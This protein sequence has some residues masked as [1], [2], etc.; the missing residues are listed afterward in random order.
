MSFFYEKGYLYCDEL[1]VKT[2]CEQVGRTPFYL[3]SAQ[4]LHKNLAAYSDAIA[5]I[6]AA[7]SYAVKANA[8]LHILS[9]VRQHGCWA[10]LV[11]G[12]ELQLALVSGFDPKHMIFNGNGKTI[13][14][15]KSAAELGILINI[16]SEFD[17]DH[18]QQA[19]AL[20]GKSVDVLLRIN[21]DIDPEVHPYISTGV[22]N[23][24][25]GISTKDIPALLTRLKIASELNLVGLH[26][27]L[28]STI[29]NLAVFRQIMNLM[30]DQFKTIR[31]QGFRIKYLNIGGGL[32]I[33]YLKEKDGFPTP[34][35][36]I[37]VLTDL[38][39]EHAALI[40]EPGRS[41][42][43]SAGVLI[44]N[45]I[46]IKR[47]GSRNFIVT[48]GSM[49]ELIR[50]SLYGA[51]HHINFIEPV[52]G[53]I[54]KYDIVGPVCESADFLG[55]DRSLPTPDENTGMIIYDAGAYGYTM[56]SNYNMRP[57][58]AEYLVDGTKLILIRR[59]ENLDDLM[60]LFEIGAESTTS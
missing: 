40:L 27:H 43:G 8:N 36:L 24:K 2:I 22:K 59:A 42:V 39:P 54:E 44:C 31:T 32:G 23:S 34:G 58:P 47:G 16:D 56:S 38:I 41:I 51:Y 48:D 57:R 55:K 26:C 17:L 52:M 19:A 25:F 28:G 29:T 5:D 50:P 18:I 9:I 46:G 30:V 1:R 21:P 20:T 7:I 60:R 4:T 10:T 12:G 33:D 49:T 14:E 35:D 3:Y 37:S 53:P 13:P 11:S 15:L 6:P 45:V